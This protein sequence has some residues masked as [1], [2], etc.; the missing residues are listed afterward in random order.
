MDEVNKDRHM[1]SVTE[2][3]DLK[4]RTRGSESELRKNG[5]IAVVTEQKTNYTGK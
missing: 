4:C 1:V 3:K 5:F 2:E